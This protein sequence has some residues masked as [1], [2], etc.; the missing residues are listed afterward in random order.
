MLEAKDRGADQTGN[1][2]KCCRWPPHPRSRG[3]SEM[4]GNAPAPALARFPLRWGCPDLPRAT[5]DPEP[6]KPRM[7]VESDPVFLAPLCS[8]RP[9]VQQYRLSAKRRQGLHSPSEIGQRKIGRLNR[10]QEPGFS[11]G[12]QGFDFPWRAVIWLNGNRLTSPRRHLEGLDPRRC[13]AFLDPHAMVERQIG[14]FLHQSARPANRRAHRT[15]RCSET[16]KDI[17]AVLGKKSRSSL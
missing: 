10:S 13:R 4:K 7:L 16:E 5:E 8:D 3:G 9:K 1:E 6:P 17:L 2:K 12:G 11:P 14:E 15:L